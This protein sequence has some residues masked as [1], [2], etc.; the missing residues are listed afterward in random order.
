MEFLTTI[1]SAVV[2]GGVLFFVFCAGLV[3][4]Y[5]FN[6]PKNAATEAAPEPPIQAAVEHPTAG[7]PAPEPAP[8]P[9][10]APPAPEPIAAPDVPAAAET[11]EVDG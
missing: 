9:W 2:C 7:T 4:W 11:P 6:Q 5:L 1:G 3:F 10:T 8:S